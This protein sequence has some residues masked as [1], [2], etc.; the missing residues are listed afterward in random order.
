MNVISD[1][2]SR[3]ATPLKEFLVFP[4]FSLVFLCFFQIAKATEGEPAITT[5]NHIGTTW[6]P[7]GNYIGTI[8]KNK[9]NIV[10]LL[11]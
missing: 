9:V 2:G 6:E 10:A 7:N 11:R 5:K 3:F 1:L 8:T 4:M